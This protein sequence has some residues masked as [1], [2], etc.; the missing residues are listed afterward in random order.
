LWRGQVGLASTQ[1]QPFLQNVSA[2]FSLGP[3]TFAA[4]AGLFGI[5]R[6]HAPSG[7]SPQPQPGGPSQ[8]TGTGL[9]GPGP[10][11]FGGGMVGGYNPGGEGGGRGFNLSVRFS[12]FRTRD[13]LPAGIVRTPSLQG[14]RQQMTLNM[15]FSPTPHWS[16][17]WN[18]LYDL[19]TRRFGQH[20]VRLERDLHRWHASFAFSRT[21]SGNFAFSFYV[22]LL[23]EPD[24]KFDYDQQSYPRAA[25]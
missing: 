10:R 7:P 15:S 1:F 4:I 17:S 12:S 11:G 8:G 25:P 9:Q 16:A 21:A 24:I 23:D 14:G 18:T 3:R 22:A 20:Y 13:T 19:D 5:G 2:A 6:G